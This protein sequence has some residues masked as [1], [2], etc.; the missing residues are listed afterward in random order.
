M[1]K[2]SARSKAK[3]SLISSRPGGDGHQVHNQ[4]LL[5]L[6]RNER[7]RLLPKLELVRLQSRLILHEVGETL[8][9]AYFCNTGLISIL[10][11]FPDGKSV[12][13]GLVGKEGFVGS[14][15]V[16]YAGA[17]AAAVFPDH[18]DAGD[19]DCSLQPAP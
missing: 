3:D 5:A 18:G 11:V 14:A 9:S 19:P 4:I 2:Q 12:E 10:S 1:A 13:V 17:D 16:R 6:P 7:E 8:Q 15:R